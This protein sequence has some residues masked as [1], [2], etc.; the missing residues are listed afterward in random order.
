MTNC[1]CGCDSLRAYMCKHASHTRVRMQAAFKASRM[2]LY[3]VSPK[4][5][6]GKRWYSL[7]GQACAGRG[8]HDVSARVFGKY[9]LCVCACVRWCILHNGQSI[10][11]SVNQAPCCA[12]LLWNCMQY[13]QQAREGA[14]RVEARMQLAKR[15]F[16]AVAAAVS[17][18]F[19]SSR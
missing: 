11:Q 3:P 9:F 17:S 8:R 10:N 12:R 6:G 5:K 16:R 13:A 2:T 7:A 14:D 19:W 4:K 15:R 18:H 1:D